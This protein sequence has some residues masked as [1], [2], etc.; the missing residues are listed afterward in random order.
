MDKAEKT[1]RD[2]IFSA[3]VQLFSSKGYIETTLREIA[4]SAGVKVDSFYNYYASKHEILLS[5]LEQEGKTLAPA[6]KAEKNTKDAILDAAAQLF[7]SK[8]YTGSTLREIAEEAGI[9]VASLYHYY[10][11]KHEILLHILEKIGKALAPADEAEKKTKKNSKDAIFDAA[12]QLFSSKG[13]TETTI[14][15]IAEEAGL[16]VGSLYNHYASKHEILLDILACYAAFVHEKAHKNWDIERY[17][18]LDLPVGDRI[19]FFITPLFPEENGQKYRRALQMLLHEQFRNE[20]VRT[21]MRDCFIGANEDYVRGMV[22]D[23]IAA[24]LIAP[25]DSRLVARLHSAA[26]YRFACVTMMGIEEPCDPGDPGSLPGTL[27][28]IYEAL[29]IPKK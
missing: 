22:E 17:K 15:E 26:V 8:G 20:T 2:A 28:G 18:R 24:E 16:R 25:V 14:R 21:F 27:R 4:E 29:I 3:A 12:A 5:I 11:S 1:T 13:Y 6:G 23:L 19:L 10:A 7:S 9:R